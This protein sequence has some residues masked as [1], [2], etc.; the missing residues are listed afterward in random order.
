MKLRNRVFIVGMGVSI[1]SWGI[2]VAYAL[3]ERYG[4][5][6]E[7]IYSDST[8]YVNMP[9]SYLVPATIFVTINYPASQLAWHVG[10]YG[11]VAGRLRVFTTMILEIAFTFAWWLLLSGGAGY[12]QRWRSRRR[13]ASVQT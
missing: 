13:S 3:S 1:V 11:F 2:C 4:P 9:M 8:F 5:S 7:L 6:L 12:L 10:A